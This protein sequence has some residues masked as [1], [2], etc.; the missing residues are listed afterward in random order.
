MNVRKPPS[1][2]LRRNKTNDVGTLEILAGDNAEIPPLEEVWQ[3]SSGPL[4]VTVWA[5]DKVIAATHVQ[6]LVETS[7]DLAEL[8]RWAEIYNERALVAEEFRQQRTFETEHG[9]K[10]N[11]LFAVLKHCDDQLGRIAD[12]FGL[13]LIGRMRLGIELAEASKGLTQAAELIESVKNKSG[14]LEVIE[15]DL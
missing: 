10:I 8:V 14:E 9:P 6:R 4:P 1:E 3:Q 12:R 15:I 13:N 7:A 2:R 5:W 11:P